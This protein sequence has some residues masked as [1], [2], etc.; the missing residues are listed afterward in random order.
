MSVKIRDPYKLDAGESAFFKR[1]L[2]YIKSATFDTK[3]KDLKAFDLIPISFEAPSGADFITYRSFSKVGFAKIIADYAHDLPRADVYGEENTVKVYSLGNEYG[4]SIKEIRR[5]QMAGTNLDSRRAD[6]ARRGHDQKTNSMALNG[7]SDYS[8]NGLIDYPGITEYT[9]PAGVSTT[10]TWVT[11]TPDEIIADL[12]GIVSAVVDTTN[13]VGIPDTMIMPLD[14]FLYI[15]NTRMTGDSD[16]NILQF[17][18]QNNPF[19]K[20][21]EWLTELKGAGVGATDRFMIYTQDPRNLTL[22]LPQAFEQFPIQWKGLEG[23]VPCHSETA[24]V[25]VYYP[26][27]VAFGDG[28]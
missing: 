12:S 24:G 10:K 2:E 23:V 16:K 28:I 20:K 14:Q 18:L 19:I 15:T 6:A 3:Y 9:V 22:E 25:I 4:Y 17:F 7:D 8:I 27:E 1:Q 11:K 26:L 5:S 13:G 21:V